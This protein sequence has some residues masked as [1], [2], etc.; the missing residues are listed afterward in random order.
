MNGNMNPWDQPESYGQKKR[1][2]DL[3]QEILVNW[4]T[5]DTDDTIQDLISFAS[6]LKSQF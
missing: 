6:E 4:T 2:F 3:F 1:V 5:S